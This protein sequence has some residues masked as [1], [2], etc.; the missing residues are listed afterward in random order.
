MGTLSSNKIAGALVASLFWGVLFPASALG[1]DSALAAPSAGEIEQ[2]E[3]LKERIGN[4]AEYQKDSKAG[5]SVDYIG[6]FRDESRDEA[7][8]SQAELSIAQKLSALPLRNYGLSQPV[9]RCAASVCEIMIV[10]DASGTENPDTNWQTLLVG[11]TQGEAI[12][13]AVADVM[14]LMSSVG[15]EK[16][17]FVTYMRVDR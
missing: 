1:W 4:R 14:T 15:S 3:R 10:Q 11:L 9:V 16:T 5:G 8:A 6:V 17:G 13:V 12:G 2:L 7:W